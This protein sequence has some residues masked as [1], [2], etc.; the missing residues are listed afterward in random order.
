M[1]QRKLKCLLF[2]FAATLSFVS[3]A[4]EGVGVSYDFNEEDSLFL[5]QKL[6]ENHLKFK[7]RLS[8]KIY[9]NLPRVEITQ[10]RCSFKVF[11]A[12]SETLFRNVAQKF[13][14]SLLVNKYFKGSLLLMLNKEKIG[15]VLSLPGFRMEGAFST[16]LSQI[17]SESLSNES[18]LQVGFF[19]WM[20]EDHVFL[21][22]AKKINKSLLICQKFKNSKESQSCQVL[23]PYSES[24]INKIDLGGAS[25]HLVFALCHHSL[26]DERLCQKLYNRELES[27]Q[28]SLYSS[29]S[30]V[31][32]WV[33][34]GR[35]GA[36][37]ESPR[38]ECQVNF[39]LK[40]YLL[41][42]DLGVSFVK[43]WGNKF[44]NAALT[45]RGQGTRDLFL[46]LKKYALES[47]NQSE[48][49]TY[50]LPSILGE[51]LVSVS[52]SRHQSPEDR[53]A[54]LFCSEKIYS[55]RSLDYLLPTGIGEFDLAQY[56]CTIISSQ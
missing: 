54:S 34:Y 1:K 22:N 16:F 14:C 21:G 11:R 15:G 42:L 8:F 35:F 45:V 18:V 53:R 30:Y 20:G 33:P 44:S 31:G 10:A 50:Q 43:G 2:F 4:Q 6:Q 52:L 46:A 3:L 7:D 29:C 55:V 24:S 36:I 38:I 41:V 28:E 23:V 56:E 19:D 37:A 27:F 9:K 26:K 32:A 51:S 12:S 49:S 25:Q 13:V 5:A 39:A 47:L 17:I 40:D 48:I